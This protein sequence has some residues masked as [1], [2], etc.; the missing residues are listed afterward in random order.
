VTKIWIVKRFVL[1]VGF[2]LALAWIGATYAAEPR[3]VSTADDGDLRLIKSDTESVI[4]ELQMSSYEVEETTVNGTTYHIVR[5]PGCGQTDDVGRPQLPVRGVLLGIPTTAE[6][7][8]R[9]IEVEEEV[10]SE[11]ESIYPVPR[12]VLETDSE[13]D[14][15]RIRYEFA[16][17]EAV[18]SSDALYPADVAE[19][20][21]SGFIRDQRVVQIRF[22]PFR[23]NPV[24]GELRR[25]TRIRV[26]LAFSY[27]HGQP[28]LASAREEKD[29]FG[30]VLRNALLNYDSARSWREVSPASASAPVARLGQ[31]G[32]GYKVLVDEDGIYQLS[33]DEIESAGMELAGVQCSDLELFN[34]GEQVAIYVSDEGEDGWFNEGDSLLFYGQEMTTTYAYT[35]VYWLTTGDGNGLRM[36][37]REGTLGAGTVLTYFNTTSHWEEDVEYMSLLPEPLTIPSEEEDDHW[38]AGYLFAPGAPGLPP[39]MT[40]AMT[41]DDLSVSS[42][43]YSG[44][45]RGGFS[46]DDTVEDPYDHQ[47]KVYLNGHEVHEALWSGQG[48]YEFETD[49]PDSYLLQG[50]NTI[51][52]ECLLHDPLV[53]NQDIVH[54]NWF[55]IDYRRTY[56]VENEALLFDGDE[57][58]TWQFEVPG[59]LTE[60]VE[61][62]DVTDPFSVTRMVSTTVEPTGTYTLKFED[63]IVGEHQYLGL[64]PARYQSAPIVED[65]PSDLR[66]SS[67][68]ADY[69]IITHPDF[70]DAVSGLA[71]HRAAQGL[72]VKVV[73]VT[74]IYD[75]FNYG[76]FHPSAIRDLLAYAYANWQ[77]PA[78]SYVLLVGDGNWDFKDHLG[79]GEPNYIPPYLIYADEWIG[80]A[81]AD[82]RYVCVSGDDVLPDMHI[83]RL[84]AQTV[85]QVN[86]M[87]DKILDYENS[88]PEGA[89]RQEV[90]F[91]ADE[92]SETPDLFRSLADDVVDHHVPPADLYVTEK[93]YYGISPYLS[94][95]AVRGAILDAFDNGR[96]FINY[97]GHG[98]AFSWAGW[99]TGPFLTR[100]DVAA[101][102][103]SDNTP[104]ILAMACLEGYFIHPSS[105]EEDLSCLAESLVRAQGKGPV[106][107]WS[108]ASFGLSSGQ[109][110]LHAG[111]YDA[112]FRDQVYQ[113]GPATDL[114]KLNLYQHASGDH[115]ELIDTYT[116]FGDPALRLPLESYAAFLPL[117]LRGY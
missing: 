41:L 98:S 1:F 53:A 83:G 109:H 92:D 59:F 38:F 78:P 116:V 23:Y 3:I 7:T 72:R 87:I 93:V 77:P 33:Y 40:V 58:G 45:L 57:T 100:N 56:S 75:E 26:E 55:E 44:T 50:S 10:V 102:S 43:P 60:A 24:D 96:L 15:G 110:Y 8:L 36:P 21:S 70:R 19:L 27:P 117:A 25:A 4:V 67:N 114:G 49:V 29:S 90:L 28:V 31:S 97:V 17:D 89:W 105:P 20:G 61:V 108:P 64:T 101:L 115:R 47:V 104:I 14:P 79:R 22:F 69:I 88:L 2:C 94:G 11:R 113:L 106:A 76:V 39:T 42:P 81:S 73:D 9:V 95:D 16:V 86:S 13:G 65:T 80:E 84:P 107:S 6:Y 35:N 51:S 48:K 71:N 34:Q 82:N 112:V 62:F 46:G 18:Y 32:S 63:S 37:E 74:D 30:Q 12:P 111:F 68:G 103:P 91:V 85:T 99:P 54:V 52:V 66:N 5:T